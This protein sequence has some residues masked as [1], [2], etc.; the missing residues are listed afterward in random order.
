[1]NI[2]LALGS[3]GAKGYSHIGVIRRLEKEGYC[4]QAIAGTSFGALVGIFYSLGYSPDEIEDMFAAGS[5]SR[6]YGHAGNGEPSFLGLAGAAQLL[7]KVI[8]NRTFEDLRLPCIV[9]ASDLKTGQV[10]SLRNG[11]LMDAILA[12]VAIPG[13]FPAHRIGEFELV[14]GGMLNPV[15]VAD[16]RSLAPPQTPV[17]AVVLTAPLGVP[18]DLQTIPLPSYLPC[19]LAEAIRR[20]R[21]V[22]ALDVIFLSQDMLNRAVTKYHLEMDKPEVIIRP[23]VSHLNALERVDVREVARKGEKAVEAALRDLEKLFMWRVDSRRELEV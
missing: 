17:I 7:R 19:K 18:A 16:A 22:R 8:G 1:M 21:Y 14:D 5:Q 12:T 20:M 4:I 23:Q 3:G 6:L 13:I 11:S 2:T 15:P 9:T 10:V